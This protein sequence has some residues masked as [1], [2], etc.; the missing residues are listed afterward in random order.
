MVRSGIGRILSLL[1]TLLAAVTAVTAVTARAAD[2][3]VPAPAEEITI[4]V[5]AKLGAED[6]LARWSAT[7]EYLNREIPGHRFRVVPMR[8]DEIP[9]LVRNA[10]VDFV[11]VNPAI[12]VELEVRYGARRISSLINQLSPSH[13]V[14]RFGSVL[15]TRAGLGAGVAPTLEF[16][17]GRRV[18]AVH[19]TSLGGWLIALRE[20]RDAGISEESFTELRFLDNH[21][22]VVEE[23]LEGRADV[24]IVRSDT[25]ERMAQETGRLATDDGK[26][27]LDRIA[28]INPQ[29][30]PDF[31]FLIST[32][33]YPEWPI[34]KLAHV[35][36]EVAREVAVAL[37]GLADGDPAAVAA[38]I[39]GWTVPENYQPVREVLRELKVSPYDEETRIS[40]AR[41]LRAYWYW[42]V[43]AFGA[44]ALLTFGL[45][46]M[47][48]LNVSLGRQTAQLRDSQR[49]FHA[50]FEQAAVGIAH[51]SVTGR[52]L[53]ANRR[54]CELS[55]FSE[56]ELSSMSLNDLATAEELPGELLRYEELRGGH[57]GSFSVAKRLVRKEGG[58]RWVQF[59]VS[60]ARGDD[61][62]IRFLVVVVDDLEERKALEANLERERRGRELILEVAGEGILGLDREGRHTF[63]NPAA[64]QLLGYDVEELIG[65][66]S[67]ST[68]HHS[69]PDGTPFPEQQCPITRVLREGAER[70]SGEE[71]FWRKNGTPLPVSFISTP[72][73]EGGEV[74]GAVVLFREREGVVAPHH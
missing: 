61:G 17:R 9:V 73:V 2:E 60:A 26:N 3:A 19:A 71:T 30:H 28:V 56:A 8:F 5:L 16:V 29:R 58:P 65:K 40:F 7:A 45:A 66:P 24:G 59:T 47:E 67:H 13:H 4:G 74:A 35:D 31:P 10:L 22:E 72:L 64:A 50:T 23:V 62:R 57:T 42:L 44:V 68:W 41:V 12:Y 46:R 21:R 43:A 34:A 14:A 69:R 15:F 20:L 6:A 52:L 51:A 38:K 39:H 48:R 36:N 11:I 33:L 18:A 32:R 27:V 54:L 25:L 70:I 49:E 1:L 55:G 63:I 37:M 53:R